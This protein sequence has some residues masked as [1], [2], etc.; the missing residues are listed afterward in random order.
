MNNSSFFTN[1][2]L[3]I[4]LLNSLLYSQTDDYEH[5]IKIYG[6]LPSLSG[7][8]TF[9]VPNPEPG[10]P[11][12]V[13]SNLA[14]AI[15]MVFMG[16]YK[17]QKNK[18]SLQLDAIYLA[19]S[20][21]SELVGN[22]NEVES[23]LDAWLAALYG[24]YNIV[25]NQDVRFDIIGGLRYAYLKTEAKISIVKDR[26]LSQSVD[27]YD[28]V[29]GFDGSVNFTEKWFAPYHFDIGM[30]TSDLTYRA[31]TGIGY[32]FGWGDVLLEYRYLYY[33]VAE[34]KLLKDIEFY[35]PLIGVNFRF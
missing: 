19:M 16:T 26:T 13:E 4:I 10:E 28:G 15:D 18:Y 8:A 6:W 3:S 33:D 25:D 11:E 34:S 5:Q 32:G 31:S 30:G 1:I 7:T 22:D 27:L 17:V 2:A 35:G 9:E 23:S 21:N 14:E 29:I 20:T 24:G 12:E